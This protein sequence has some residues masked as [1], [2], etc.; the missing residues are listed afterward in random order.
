M[1]VHYA[2]IQDGAIIEFPT[3]AYYYM[4]V[5]DRDGKGGVVRLSTGEFLDRHQLEIDGLGVNCKVVAS[6]IE[7]FF[8]D[9]EDEES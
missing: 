9:Y 6:D 2:S 4:K 7:K 5:C 8:E 1:L 3:S